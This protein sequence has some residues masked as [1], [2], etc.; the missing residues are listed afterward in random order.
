MK[1]GK[2]TFPTHLSQR[3]MRRGQRIFQRYI[4]INGF[5]IAFLMNDLLIL[6][7]IRNGLSDPQLAVLASFMHLTMPFMV[8]GKQLIPKYG[9]SRMWS[10]AWFMRYLSGSVLILAPFVGRAA[11]QWVVSFTVLAAVFGFSLLR[12]IGLTANS[13]MMGE[14]TTSRDRGRFISG[15]WMRAQASNLISMILVIVV[16]RYYSELWVYQ[17]LIGV[18]CLVGFYGSTLLRHIPETSAPSLSARKPIIESLLISFRRPRYRRT[19]IAWAAG[20]SIYVLVIPFSIILIKNGYGISDYEALMFS[21]LLLM[22]GIAAALINSAISDRVGPR[23]LMLIYAT[24][25]FLVAG[26]WAL[27][28]ASFYPVIV[29]TIF[30]LSGFCKTGINVGI[31]HYFLTVADVQDRVGTSMFGR[32]F[33]GAAAGLA[34][35]VVGGGIL[36]VLRGQDMSGLPLYRMYFMFIFLLLLPLF[37]AIFRLEKLKEWRVISVLSLL[38]S[39]RDLRAI[40]VMNRLD[41]SSAADDDL[42]HV[43]RLEQIASGLS[44]PTL[45]SLL[46]SPRLSVRVH[47]MRALREIEFGHKTAEAL[48]HELKCGEFTSAWNAAEILGEHRIEAAVPGLRA[49]LESTDPFLV[50]KCMVSLVQLGDRESWPRILELFREADNPRIIIHGANAFIESGAPERTADL[51]EKLYT[52]ELYG[53][54]ADEL[55]NAVATL[56][57]AERD[58]YRFLREYNRDPGQGFS[59][60]QSELEHLTGRVF[61]GR[62][63]AGKN[64]TGKESRTAG[65]EGDARAEIL[66]LTPAGFFRRAEARPEGLSDPTKK[67]SCLAYVRDFVLSREYGPHGDDFHLKLLA[68]LVMVIGADQ[69]TVE[70]AEIM[71]SAEGMGGST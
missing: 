43:Q 5:T 7:G 33:S 49:G 41:Q 57:G 28:P 61:D 60:L 45:R 25:F 47:A 32:M 71:E 38:F 63:Q 14:I 42:V 35:S 15:N 8:I 40:Y 11:P 12:S 17:I 65:T 24:G 36:T 46:D 62:G 4:T 58:F 48:I 67:P 31:S 19:M 37:F 59:L 53:P 64:P 23:P 10:T 9:L 1:K 55:L 54:V 70:G 50:G 6:Y 27:A 39:M 69:E 51:L 52:A 68:C 30:F 66:R 16:M 22:G 13:P 34:G 44:E 18:G 2:M 56:C 29:G 26:Y 20:Y 21:L 3:E